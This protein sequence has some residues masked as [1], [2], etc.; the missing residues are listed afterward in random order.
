MTVLLLS[1]RPPRTNKIHLGSTTVPMARCACLMVLFLRSQSLLLLVAAKH[2]KSHNNNNN[3]NNYNGNRYESLIQLNPNYVPSRWRPA[4]PNYD[5]LHRRTNRQQQQ[6]QQLSNNDTHHNNNN[7]NNGNGDDDDDNTVAAQ[8]NSSNNNDFEDE[9][10]FSY[11]QSNDNDYTS[12]RTRRRP[13]QPPIS[14]ASGMASYYNP[15]QQQQQ[16]QTTLLY[17]N[18]NTHDNLLSLMRECAALF[19]SLALTTTVSLA[20]FGSWQVPRLKRGVLQKWFVASLPNLQQGR[21]P[22][23]VLSAASHAN[24]FHIWFNLL[25]LLSFGPAVQ[26]SLQSHSLQKWPLWPLLLGAAVAGSATFLVWTQLIVE[27]SYYGGC[28]GLSAVTF[29]LMTVH[30]RM[31]PQA[32]MRML[33]GGVVPI[34]MTAQILLATLCS[35]T[36]VMMMLSL[37]SS[38]TK[39]HN[40]N[41][42]LQWA[43]SSNIAHAAHLGGILFGLVYYEVWQRRYRIG[44]KLHQFKRHFFCTMNG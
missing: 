19:P 13:Q 17:S 29:A 21:W 26:Q 28:M 30:S 4:N 23:L 37:W 24:V 42:I 12:R 35:T 41:P 31:T 43:S 22:S 11:V 44:W 15:N 38:K 2:P 34:Q 39:S 7:N 8:Q 27:N 16:P 36:V 40:R 25:A 20:V 10:Y 33:V 9:I 18:G 5:Y 1:T 6:T 32:R 3:N 14:S